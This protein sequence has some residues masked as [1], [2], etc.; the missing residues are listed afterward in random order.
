MMGSHKLLAKTVMY[1]E[2]VKVPWLMRV[3]QLGLNQKVIENPVSHIDMVPTLM[4]LMGKRP[5]D[6]FPGQS[7]APLIRGGTVKE[8]HVYIEWN[9][10]VL[11]DKTPH[12]IPTVSPEDVQRVHRAYTR[13]VIS[14]DGWK[15]CLSDQDNS[16]LFN[17]KEDPGE[18]N[19][20]FYTNVHKDIIANLT[21]KIDAWQERAKD[22]A[23]V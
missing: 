11:R 10:A 20:L 2:A 1:E 22:T 21:K 14:P 17:L 15:L 9:P 5:G 7:L 19:N 8:D 3:P 6:L 16:Q 12:S 18:T 13:T 4:D 23:T